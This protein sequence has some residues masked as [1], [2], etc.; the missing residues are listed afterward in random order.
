MINRKRVRRRR[1]AIGLS[2][3]HT[4]LVLIFRT[5]SASCPFQYQLG[6]LTISLAMTIS[7]SVHRLV[8][9]TTSRHTTLRAG[10]FPPV[11]EGLWMGICREQCIWRWKSSDDYGCAFR[12]A[13][14]P[15]I[16]TGSTPYHSAIVQSS[17]GDPLNG[18]VGERLNHSSE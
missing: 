8:A 6:T 7:I 14:Y 15:R 3:I 18:L 13:N 16:S 17:V 12:K 10:H 11:P 4:Q 2:I 1:S 9:W 5:M